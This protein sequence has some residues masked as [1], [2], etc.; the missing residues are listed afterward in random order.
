VSLRL[1]WFN[2]IGNWELESGCR[3]RSLFE[4]CGT[5]LCGTTFVL[6][7]GTGQALID[8]S[9]LLQMIFFEVVLQGSSL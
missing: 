9:P 1:L 8:L 3:K 7:V 5:A 2:Q 6:L 4:T